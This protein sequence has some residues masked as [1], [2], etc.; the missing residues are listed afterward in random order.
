MNRRICGVFVFILIPACLNAAVTR[1]EIKTRES[2][3]EGRAFDG[4]VHTN[5]CAARL[6]LRL[7]PS[8][9]PTKQ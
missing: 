8:T 5:G 1:V 3:L 2:Y 7:I 9:S 6:S 4:V